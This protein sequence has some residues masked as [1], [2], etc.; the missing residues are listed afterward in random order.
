MENKLKQILLI[1][2]DP[3]TQMLHQRAISKAGIA[4]NILTAMDG[5]EGIELITNMLDKQQPLPCLILLDINMPKMN[6]WE[7][8]E[9]YHKITEDIDEET[10]NVVIMLTTSL[11][12]SDKE[13]ASAF[14]VVK[15]FHPKP[16][17]TEDISTIAEDCI[18]NI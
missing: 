18:N 13:K 5:E 14:D 8:L 3:P 4:D 1:D 9:A 6:G 17:L 12:P 15:G 2:D 10:R 16:L 7:F 11:N